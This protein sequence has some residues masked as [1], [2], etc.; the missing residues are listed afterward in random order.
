MKGVELACIAELSL[1]NLKSIS[2]L[3]FQKGLE[4][5]KGK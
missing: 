4:S 1:E 5:I 3:Y 2:K